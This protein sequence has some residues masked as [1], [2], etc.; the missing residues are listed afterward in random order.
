MNKLT[1]TDLYSLEEYAA[2]RP[3]FRAKIMAHKKNRVIPVGPNA[4]VHFEDRL[5]MHYQVQEMLRAERVFEAAGIQEELDAYNPLIPDGHNWKATLMIEYD[6]PDERA[7]QLA[8]LLGVEDKT[9]VRVGEHDRVHP[10]A[11]EDMERTT[12]D[13]TS[14]VHFLRFELTAEMIA[15]ARAGA[16]IGVGIDH[17]NYNHRIDPLPEGA[18]A[19]L[20]AD[21]Q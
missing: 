16:A 5:L 2:M 8:K 1:R 6:D 11:D 14:S 17:P 3:E 7:E 4:T 15:D 18:S 9:W 19:S 21:L 12:E 10:I 13:K 20:A